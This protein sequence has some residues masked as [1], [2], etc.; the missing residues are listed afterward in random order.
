MIFD[1]SNICSYFV[2]CVYDKNRELDLGYVTYAVRMR[3]GPSKVAKIVTIELVSFIHVLGSYVLL[4]CLCH[5]CLLVHTTTKLV[6]SLP[7]GS[8]VTQTSVR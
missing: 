4:L 8:T 3:I 7:L 6:C 1:S 5:R 2:C